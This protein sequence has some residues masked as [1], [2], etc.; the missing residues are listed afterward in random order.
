MKLSRS[1]KN[2]TVVNIGAVAVLLGLVGTLIDE[3]L[4]FVCAPLLLLGLVTVLVGFVSGSDD[5]A[6]P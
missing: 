2:K 6:R 3:H 4:G 1:P 5:N